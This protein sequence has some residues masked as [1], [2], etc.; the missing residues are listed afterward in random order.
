MNRKQRL[1]LQRAAAAELARRE[2]Y[3]EISDCLTAGGCTVEEGLKELSNASL[4]SL[5]PRDS[6]VLFP[7]P[8]LD[9]AMR[10]LADAEAFRT[11]PPIA[12]PT[13]PAADWPA[14]RQ[15]FDKAM[16]DRDIRAIYAARV[17]A[18]VLLL[19]QRAEAP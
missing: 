4:A 16:A 5:C 2:E 6:G 8:D 9:R 17:A 10:M 15:M 12:E 14:I 19:L 18:E 11:A 1:E 3:Q 7:L 13:A